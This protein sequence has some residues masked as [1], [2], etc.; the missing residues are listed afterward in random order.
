MR[1]ERLCDPYDA[2]AQRRALEDG[3]AFEGV[4][5]GSAPDRGDLL[6]FARVST[7]AA[8]PLP[9]LLPDPP[10]GGLTDGAVRV[11]PQ[12]VG[13]AD[14][15]WVVQSDP[16]V[17][18]W[19]WRP[20]GS[21][22]AHL[23]R[24]RATGSSWLLGQSA[25]WSVLDEATGAV[26][27]DVGLRVMDAVTGRANLGYATHPAWRRR[28]VATRAA[29]LVAAWAWGLPGL[30][31]VE[32]SA[33]PDNTASLAVL[34]RAGFVREGLLRGFLPSLDG[35]RQDVVPFSWQPDDEA[36]SPIGPTSQGPKGR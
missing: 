4:R 26:V 32:A 10:E 28:G 12:E 15:L 20:L 31:R 8:G 27:G 22:A 14:A 2:P 34:E 23:D 24:V 5:R 16:A 13:D 9:R 33:H 17:V 1:L 25:A 30:G 21:V 19:S 6:V 36:T 18:R 11:R 29:R 3:L 7:D 35:G